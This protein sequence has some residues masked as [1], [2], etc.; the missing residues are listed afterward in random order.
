MTEP[1]EV[2]AGRRRTRQEVQRLVRE[3][4]TSGLPRGEFCRIHGMTLGTLQRGLNRERIKSND[5]QTDGKRLVRVKVIGGSGAGDDQ[6]LCGMAAVLAN[7]RRIEFN[8]DFDAAQLRRAVTGLW[9][10]AK[11]L[12]RG[13]YSWPLA[14][15]GSDRVLLSHEELSLLLGGIDLTHTRRK[16]WYRVTVSGNEKD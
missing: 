11:R 15:D 1:E 4:A 13:R 8:P 5:T 10:C 7:G 14:A 12:K 9:S 16:N 3:F 2:K 6:R